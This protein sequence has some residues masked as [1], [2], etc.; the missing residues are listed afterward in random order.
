M[1]IRKVWNIYVKVSWLLNIYNIIIQIIHLVILAL[2]IK[3]Q[4]EAN[5]MTMN[6]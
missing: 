5:E 1:S 2:E 4:R 6:K 3:K